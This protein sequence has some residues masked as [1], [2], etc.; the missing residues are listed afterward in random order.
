M[1]AATIAGKDLSPVVN[2]T[3]KSGM[4][5]TIDV[6]VVDMP[7]LTHSEVDVE[8]KKFPKQGLPV[9]GWTNYPNSYSAEPIE[10]KLI[11]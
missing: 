7:K 10:M 9:K 2:N 3:T 4:P 8:V 1:T 11:N 5:S 6:R